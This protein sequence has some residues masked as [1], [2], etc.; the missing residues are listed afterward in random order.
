MARTREEKRLSRSS[1]LASDHVF[2]VITRLCRKCPS[3]SFEELED[4]LGREY[5]AGDRTYQLDENPWLDAL[6]GA[7]TDAMPDYAGDVLEDVL[8]H[9]RD[10]GRI[11]WST[12]GIRLP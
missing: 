9:L 12:D 8:T 2:A 1:K 11:T 4:A 10:D 5:R 3:I 7:V 6:D